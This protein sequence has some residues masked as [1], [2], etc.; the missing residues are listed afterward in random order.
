MMEFRRCGLMQHGKGEPYNRD[1]TRRIKCVPLAV[2]LNVS[3]FADRA[4]HYLHWIGAERR[5]SA[6]RRRWFPNANSTRPAHSLQQE[7]GEL[8]FVIP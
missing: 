4:V 6:M 7:F 1:Y 5:Q 8:I 3:A 2:P